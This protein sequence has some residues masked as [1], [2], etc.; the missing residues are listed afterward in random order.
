LYWEKI[1]RNQLI[2]IRSNISFRVLLNTVIEFGENVNSIHFI[3]VKLN[4]VRGFA[5]QIHDYTSQQV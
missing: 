1:N 5:T 2:F 4:C 3:W